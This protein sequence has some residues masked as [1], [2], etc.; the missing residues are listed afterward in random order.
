MSGLNFE[1]DE[2]WV[3]KEGEK[4]RQYE[5][6]VPNED[7]SAF[8]LEYL[9]FDRIGLLGRWSQFRFE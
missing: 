1:W 4:W 5:Y 3:P 8:K 9:Q 6:Y 2:E 7:E